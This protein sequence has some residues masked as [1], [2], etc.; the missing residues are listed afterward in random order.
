MVY[1]RFQGL[2]VLVVAVEALLDPKMNP[3]ILPNNGLNRGRHVDQQG[4]KSQR[5]EV[6]AQVH[7]VT[8]PE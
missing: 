1:G 7:W 8:D 3:N 6:T 5:R 2:L 4:P